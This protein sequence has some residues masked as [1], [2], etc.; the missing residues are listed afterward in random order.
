[1]VLTSVHIVNF[2]AL[3]D[4]TLELSPLTVLVGPNASGKSSVLRA[5][6]PEPPGPIDLWRHDRSL[7]ALVGYVDGPGT[8]AA[9]G[10]AEWSVQGGNWSNR[11]YRFQFL[12]LD[13][14]DLRKETRLEA[15]TMLSRSGAGIANVFAALPRAQQTEVSKRYGCG[16]F[17]T[18]ADGP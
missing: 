16:S 18:T 1:V 10:Q 15:E 9:T 6:D 3:K 7:S 14:A 4:V 5:L 17:G 2:R 13:V 11:P 8:G 12:R